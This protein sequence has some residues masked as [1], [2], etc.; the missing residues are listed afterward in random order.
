MPDV[1]NHGA[2]YFNRKSIVALLI[3]GVRLPAGT[4]MRV[5]NATVSQQQVEQMLASVFPG[6]PVLTFVTLTTDAEVEEF[7]R[8][9]PTTSIPR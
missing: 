3:G 1:A 2:Y 4:W 8:S 5:V 6:L 7:E 9:W